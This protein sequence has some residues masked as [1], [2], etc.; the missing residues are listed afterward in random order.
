MEKPLILYSCYTWLSYKI[1]EQYYGNRHYVWCTP[2]LNPNSRFSRENA[3]PPTS[4]PFEIYEN[5]YKEV[6]RGERHSAKISQNRLGILRGANIQKRNGKI[7]DSA[8]QD[9]RSIVKEAQ[10]ADFRP[11][12]F[13][14]PFE[15]VAKRI[16]QVAIKDRAH[17]LS[18][19]FIIEHLERDA[20]DVIELR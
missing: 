1:N 7:N 14:I 18:Q 5:L 3:V 19:E 12:I 16:V 9:I 13:V 10:I 11:L 6:D 4:S 15:P 2:F 20:F 8:H 17:P